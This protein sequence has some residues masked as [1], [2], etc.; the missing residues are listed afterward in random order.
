MDMQPIYQ[1]LKLFK[2]QGIR[3]QLATLKNKLPYPYPLPVL[4]N[5][6]KQYQHDPQWI[7]SVIEAEEEPELPALDTTEQRLEQLEKNQQ[8]LL[9]RIEQ[10]EQQLQTLQQSTHKPG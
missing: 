1:A 4:I 6:L 2:Q 8:Q 5:V 3:P 10:L 9:L 7:E